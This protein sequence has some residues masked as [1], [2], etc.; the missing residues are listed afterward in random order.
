MLIGV[1]KEIKNNENRVGLVVAGVKTLVQAGHTVWV[2]RQAG[3]GCGI[4]DEMYQEAG[5]E[6]VDSPK[7]I[8]EK[9]EM[10]I[11]VKEPI[12]PELEDFREGQLLFTF[13]HLAAVPKAKAHNHKKFPR[14]KFIN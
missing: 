2:E 12:G 14:L 1:P 13:L 8:F 11:K 4:T 10:I 6:M 5:A 7:S 9:S 3:V